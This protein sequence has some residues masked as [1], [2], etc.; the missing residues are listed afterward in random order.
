[1]LAN[2]ENE[3]GVRMRVLMSVICMLRGVYPWKG[4]GVA[5]EL[6]QQ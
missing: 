5:M 1:M 3:H 4:Y 6:I 2:N